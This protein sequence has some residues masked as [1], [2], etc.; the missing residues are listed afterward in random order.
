MATSELLESSIKTA[1]SVC[2]TIMR[3]GYDAYAINAGLQRLILEYA[4]SPEVDIA[5]ACDV[6]TL[7]KIFPDVQIRQEADSMAMLEQDGVILRFYHTS[8]QNAS[9]PEHAQM[10]ITPRMVE[11]LHTLGKTDPLNFKPQYADGLSE[12]EAFEDVSCGCVKLKGIPSITLSHNY[13]LA[14]RALRYSANF[15]IPV[16]PATWMAII[17][18]AARILDYVPS[19]EIMEEWRQVAAESMWKFVQLLFY[20]HLLHGIMPEI[21][22]LACVKQDKEDGSGTETVFDHTI[23]CMKFYP[24]GEF[25]LDWYGVLAMLFHDVG[26]LY[27]AERYGD[28]WTFYQHHRVGAGV[29]RKILRRLHF[30]PED[31]DLICH[32]VRNHMM[33]HFMLTDRGL[34]RF[35]ALAETQ[36]LIE[37]SRADIKARDGSYTNFNHNQKYLERT[38]TDELMIEPLLNG[39]EIMEFTGLPPGP[40]VGTLRESLLQAQIDGKVTNTEEAITFV[41]EHCNR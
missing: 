4:K 10:R 27:T 8:V 39:N 29:T 20:T 28:R 24:E 3:N 12:D 41:K 21:A 7:A 1:V 40:E 16:D 33:F 22:A 5:C 36:R 14:V 11:V 15:D 2:K 26:K 17:Q 38:E 25:S 9:Y 35:K 19:R 34:R 37:M 13:L 6:E 30:I 18:S 23:A 31:I 32:L